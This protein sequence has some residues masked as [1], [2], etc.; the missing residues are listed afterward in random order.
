M[1]RPAVVPAEPPPLAS[2]FGFRSRTL[3]CGLS[4]FSSL[5][6]P[7]LLGFLVLGCVSRAEIMPSSDDLFVWDQVVQAD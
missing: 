1:P 2:L 4:F 3:T 7:F 5:I 6:L